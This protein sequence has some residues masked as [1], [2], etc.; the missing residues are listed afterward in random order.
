M[1]RISFP[2][3]RIYDRETFYDQNGRIVYSPLVGRNGCGGLN[4]AAKI[5]RDCPQ[6]D[7]CTVLRDGEVIA[8]NIA[9]GWKDVAGLGYNQPGIEIRHTIYDQ[10]LSDAPSPHTV[11]YI[12]PFFRKDREADY[13]E[14]WEALDKQEGTAK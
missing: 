5:D 8:E 11:S 6:H 13:R 9:L 4:N 14:V 3:M 2:I 1:Y 10:V 12:A 7:K